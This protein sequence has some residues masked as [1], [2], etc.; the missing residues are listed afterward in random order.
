MKTTHV[1]EE[2]Q[3][4]RNIP[5]FSFKYIF[6]KVS[7]FSVNMLCAAWELHYCYSDGL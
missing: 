2:L 1:E 7:G 4:Q 6:L 5:Q 3:K